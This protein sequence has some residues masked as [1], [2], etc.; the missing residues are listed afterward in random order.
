MKR[1]AELADAGKFTVAVEQVYAMTDAAQAWEKSRGGHTR[2][3]LIIQ[4]SGGPTMK[5]Q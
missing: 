1:V 2:G 3:K 5:H 4:V